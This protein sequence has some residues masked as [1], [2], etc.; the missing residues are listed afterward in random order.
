MRIGLIIT[1]SEA[2]LVWGALRLANRALEAGD[3]VEVFLVGPGVDYRQ[4]ESDTFPIGE[5]A[6][7]LVGQGGRLSA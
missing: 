5:Q 6:R 4:G 3:E 1:T 7:S 2:E